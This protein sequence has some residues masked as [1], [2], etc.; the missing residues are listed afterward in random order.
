MHWMQELLQPF[1]KTIN[2]LALDLD[3]ILGNGRRSLSQTD[4]RSLVRAL[5]ALIEADV[6]N[7]KRIALRL[8]DEGFVSFS[9]AELALLR[10]EQYVLDDK[11]LA[12]TNQKFLRLS[13]NLKFA[14]H[15]FVKA[16][17]IK[18]NIPT[19]TREWKAFQRS[20]KIRNRITH[21]KDPNDLDINEEEFQ[22]IKATF[23]WFVANKEEL[24][25]KLIARHGD[26]A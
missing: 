18:H 26:A 9:I 14:I 21:P 25:K 20:I 10:E 7:R 12:K 11:G 1:S 6:F 16:A 8:C 19:G 24:L 15:S 22:Q 4:R 23:N 5:F 17:D 2:T 13:D 3:T